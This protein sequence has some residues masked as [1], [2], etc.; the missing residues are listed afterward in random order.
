MT[1]MGLHPTRMG[2]LSIPGP[3]MRARRLASICGSNRAVEAIVD[4]T[5]TMADG[6]GI[7]ADGVGITA[8]GAEGAI[9]R[10][11]PVSRLVAKCISCKR[12]HQFRICDTESLL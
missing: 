12:T 7:T 9:K 3:I 4:I 8:A 1:P 11:H 6:A 5:G 2:P 10:T